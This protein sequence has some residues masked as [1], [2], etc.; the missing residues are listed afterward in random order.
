[1]TRRVK[2]RKRSLQ[3][4]SHSE[5]HFSVATAALLSHPWQEIQ[6]PIFDAPFL[7]SQAPFY[8]MSTIA[9]ALSLVCS[10]TSNNY[11]VPPPRP[12]LPNTTLPSRLLFHSGIGSG[13]SGATN[14]LTRTIRLPGPPVRDEAL[15]PL[16]GPPGPPSGT[17]R[18]RPLASALRPAPD[19]EGQLGRSSAPTAPGPAGPKRLMGPGGGLRRKYALICKGGPGSSA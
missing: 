2:Q 17:A 4:L 11:Q 8:H 16:T 3:S 14:R 12:S 18:R 19:A 15:L 7:D 13:L 9:Q 5:A 1:M 10:N 6:R